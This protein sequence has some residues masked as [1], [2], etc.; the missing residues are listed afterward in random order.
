[1]IKLIKNLGKREW[2]F[3][4]ICL[5]LICS[6]VWLDLKMPDYMSKITVLVQS[7]GSQILDIIINTKPFS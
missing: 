4:L 3:S 1:M 7:E 5:I 2:I 6:Q